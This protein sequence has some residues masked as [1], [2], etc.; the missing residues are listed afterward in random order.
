MAGYCTSVGP[1]FHEPQASGNTAQ[2]WKNPAIFL[3]THP[4][5]DYSDLAVPRR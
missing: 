1:Y 5:I 3:L 4:I 2:E